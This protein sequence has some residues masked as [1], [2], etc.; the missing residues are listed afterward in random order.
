MKRFL[1]QLFCKHFYIGYY[2]NDGVTLSNYQKYYD[3]WH[4][5]KCIKCSKILE[6]TEQ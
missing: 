2:T 1:K 3:D 6:V 4:V 5:K